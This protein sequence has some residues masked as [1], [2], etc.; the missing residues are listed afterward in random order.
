MPGVAAGAA[1]FAA[2]RQGAGTGAV[3]HGGS[4]GV[5]GTGGAGT[6]APGVWAASRHRSRCKGKLTCPVWLQG[7][8]RLLPEDKEL[9]RL[10][11]CT[12]VL[13]GSEAQV[14]QV[15]Q[16]HQVSGQRLAQESLQGK[17][18]CPVWLQGQL[19][20]AAGRQ[21][22]GTVAV[23]HGGSAGVRGTG[24]AGTA[25]A[26]GV[27]A[28]VGTGV[29]AAREANVPGVAAGAA[30]F[31]AG[32]LGAGT[33]VVVHGGSAGVRGTG[34]AGTGAP[35]VWA[36]VGTGVA[37][38]REANVPGVAA[39]AATFAAGR[40][41]AGRVAVVHGGSA[42]VRGTGGAGTAGERGVWAAVG[43]GVAAVAREAIVPGVAAGAATFCCRKDKELARVLLCTEV[44]R[45]SEAQVVQVLQEHQVSGQRLAQESLLQG[46]LTCPVWLQGQLR[47]LPEDKELA[48]LLCTEVLQGSE[49]QVVQVQEHQVSGQRLAQE[50]LL[51]Q[52]KLTCPVWLLEQLR[53]LEEDK[54][55][56]LLLC[57][58]VLQL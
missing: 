3:V 9:A 26:P 33:V 39:G 58:E 14:V 37:A 43:T 47:L 28:A 46:K 45:G 4:A 10:L 38:A 53:L 41:G 25:G 50:S 34:G 11:L 18:T 36:A 44:L 8:L 30:M 12:E 51:W 6:G 49:A 17:L 29:A 57:T 15:L 56:R 55:A 16:E 40:Q 24:G 22:A 7:Q 1:T 27:W 2:G 42:G 23:V 35:G 54:L 13:Q 21:G 5:R 31:A 32:R 48:V 52:G 20:F 19:R